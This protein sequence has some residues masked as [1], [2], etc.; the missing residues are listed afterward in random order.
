M[1][2]SE[3]IIRIGAE[4][5]QFQEELDKISSQTEDLENQL[6]NLAKI[7]GVVFTALIAE[8]GLAI[9][10]F[11]ESEAASNSLTQALQNQGIY[12]DELAESYKAQASALQDLT[13][14]DDDAI[15]KSQAILQSMIGQQK[16]T[17]EL[18]ASIVDLSV[19]KQMDLDTTTQ[20]IA[21]G[22]NGQTAALSKLGIVIDDNLTKEERT[23]QIIE[24]VTQAYGGQAAAA[25]QGVGS[26]KGLASAFDDVQKAIGERLAPAFTALVGVV[27]KFFQFI[28]G[29]K[30]L[31]DLIV[32]LGAAGAVVSGLGLALG[33]GAAAF[34]KIRAAMI[35]AGIAAQG[36]SLAIKGLVGATG[37]GLLVIVATELF[38]NW[39]S[40]WPKMQAVFV[41][42]ANNISALGSSLGKILLGILNPRSGLS[43]IK[44]G[45]A[46]LK[47]V[48]SKGL[49]DYETELKASHKRQEEETKASGKRQNA[50][51]KAAADEAAAQ[52]RERE[53]NEVAARRAHTE[54][55][56]LENENASSRLIETAQ[57]EAELRKAIAT[58]DNEEEK[59]ALESQLEELALVREE[60]AIMDYE[61][62]AELHDMLYEQNAEF[63]AMDEEQR[64][65][66]IDQNQSELLGMYE[67]EDTIRRQAALKR[68]Q[69]SIK[70]DNQYLADKQ[71][72]GTAYAM[73]NKAMHSEIY[74]G[75]KQA[76]GEL[77]QLQQSS[78]STL[79]SIG[80]AAAVA[81]I[82]IKTAESAMAIF[83]GFS[84]IPI[85]G[86]SLGLAGA[87]AAVAFGAEQI[88]RVTS[89]ADGGVITG[90]IPGMDSVP[91]LLMPGELV[92]PQRN[93]SDVINAVAAQQNQD[94]NGGAAGVAGVEGTVAVAIGFDGSDAEQVITAR[95]TEARALGTYRGN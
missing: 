23:A 10:A 2:S 86:P 63:Q 6:A 15:V 77:A 68:A 59:A 38:L 52:Q 91:S 92:V 75:S 42:F 19:A 53:A 62:R 85:V 32:S 12:S 72:F 21:K 93:F 26:V 61:N 49:T 60:Q 17:P 35:A 58:T 48:L 24:K 30:A 3:L 43:Q 54:A 50:A 69:E 80:K 45:Y 20:L 1:A 34:L 4:S 27:T 74:Q 41:A 40:I 28:S 37:I 76:F 29:N 18:T 81:N 5:K 31:M 33:V 87:A 11:G 47:A 9:A 51:Q 57:K 64:Q 89:A 66:F 13:G 83:A 39:N 16:I 90:G 25:N 56:A 14:V 82:I 70:A 36:T 95:Q 67:S 46:E 84:T 55:I 22:I 94:T 73:L 44:E 79:K 65:M 88:G 7:S 71:K 8:A 78:N